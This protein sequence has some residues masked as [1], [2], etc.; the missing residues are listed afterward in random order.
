MI[1]LLER[2]VI[3]ILEYLIW[4]WW[5]ILKI[6]L[7]IYIGIKPKN[8]IIMGRSIGTGPATYLASKREVG[9]LVLISPFSS[10]K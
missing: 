4:I 6:I 10:I 9:L 8:I 3:F 1:I 7:K 5:Y 2:K